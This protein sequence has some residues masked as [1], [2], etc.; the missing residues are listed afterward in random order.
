MVDLKVLAV[1]VGNQESVATPAQVTD[2]GMTEVGDARWAEPDIG[3]L[4]ECFELRTLLP[5]FADE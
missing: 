1:G 5:E 4:P 2:A 3:L